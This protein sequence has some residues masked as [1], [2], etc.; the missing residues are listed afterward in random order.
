[1]GIEQIKVKI[2]LNTALKDYVDGKV[3]LGRGDEIPTQSLIR[4]SG[5]IGREVPGLRA[6]SIGRGRRILVDDFNKSKGCR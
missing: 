5:V 1:M 6:Q 2:L 4:T 3:V